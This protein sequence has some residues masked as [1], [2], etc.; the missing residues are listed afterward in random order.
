MHCTWLFAMTLGLLGHT[1]TAT[2]PA[3]KDV[4]TIVPN[5]GFETGSIAPWLVLFSAPNLQDSGQHTTYIRQQHTITTIILTTNITGPKFSY[6][7]TSPGYNSP[8][9]LTMTSKSA[10]QFVEVD[11][12]QIEIPVCPSRKYKISAHV[13]IAGPAKSEQQL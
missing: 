10:A 1:S 13:F 4:K 5:G 6:N 2:E 9:A 11:I 7:V 8:Y 3:C 12:G